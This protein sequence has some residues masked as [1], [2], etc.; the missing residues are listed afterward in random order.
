MTRTVRLPSPI[1]R[2][3]IGQSA[4]VLGLAA[5]VAAP[6]ASSASAQAVRESAD[7]NGALNIPANPTLFG[8]SDPNVRRATAIVYLLNAVGR[9]IERSRN[10][11]GE[12]P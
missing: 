2:P 1:R 6:I 10:R 3:L 4:L 12:E 5:M 8:K 9:T 7:A 11:L